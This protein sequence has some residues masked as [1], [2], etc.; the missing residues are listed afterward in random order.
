MSHFFILTVLFC[1]FWCFCKP[2]VVF[3]FCGFFKLIDLLKSFW[4]SSKTDAFIQTLLYWV[5]LTYGREER[6]EF[7]IK[8]TIVCSKQLN[9]NFV[10][11]NDDDF[12]HRDE[13]N[14][15]V[16]K[17]LDKFFVKVEV[18]SSTV[19]HFEM[20]VEQTYTLVFIEVD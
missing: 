9:T 15:K 17:F 3:L 4:S 1:W 10:N 8:M 13:N 19:W 16:S 14:P 6:C 7:A 12:I 2:T 20:I 18:K 5:K 11:P